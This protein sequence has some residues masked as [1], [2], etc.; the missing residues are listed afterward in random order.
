M[1]LPEYDGKIRVEE[2]PT[3]SGTDVYQLYMFKPRTNSWEYNGDFFSF[4]EAV[5]F[6]R[7]IKQVKNLELV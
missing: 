3:N 5:Y 7:D 1:E 6:A 4:M 2:Y